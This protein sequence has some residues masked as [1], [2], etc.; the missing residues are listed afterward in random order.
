MLTHVKVVALLV[1]AAQISPV[2]IVTLR[3]IGQV[4]N[5]I[6]RD[7]EKIWRGKKRKKRKGK[8]KKGKYDM[9]EKKVK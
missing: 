4:I 8:L 1:P 5:T 7:E 3:I 2:L 9:Q 6:K